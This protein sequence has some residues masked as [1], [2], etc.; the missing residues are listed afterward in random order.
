M[1]SVLIVDDERLIREGLA[2]TIDWGRL[3]CELLG[4]A[5]NGR[6]GLEIIRKEKPDLVI[7]DIR[8]PVLS[9]LDM[10][11][12]TQGHNWTPQYIILSGYDDFDFARCAMEYGV[13]HYLLKPLD[14]K[15]LEEKVQIINGELKIDGEINDTGNHL[16]NQILEYLKYN[17]NQRELTLGWISENVIYKNCDYLGRL[18]K[19]HMACSFSCY[20]NK[21]RVDKAKYLMNNNREIKIYEVAEECGFPPDGQYFSTQF[22]KTTGLTPKEYM[23]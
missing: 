11:K 4:V 9:G 23:N 3:N 14:E 6:Q 7:T 22:K 1:T 10:I 17:Y 15:A 2:R 21:L 16:I 18:F 19:K 5:A 8:M 20:L 12:E 13:R